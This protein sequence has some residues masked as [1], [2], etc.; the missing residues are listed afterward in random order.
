MSVLTNKEILDKKE[1]NNSETNNE[2]TDNKINEMNNND[3]KK[4]EKEK[5]FFYKKV[6]VKPF[7]QKKLNKIDNINI[8]NKKL[9][10]KEKNYIKQINR[11]SY[12]KINLTNNNI[13]SRLGFK[14]NLNI[15]DYSM[16]L[17][18]K[19]EKYFNN[20]FSSIGEINKLSEKNNTIDSSNNVIKNNIENNKN[21][22]INERNKNDLKLEMLG[23]DKD[24]VNINYINT[25]SN[26]VYGKINSPIY[27]NKIF[28][29]SNTYNDN[30]D[31]FNNINDN[32]T[33]DNSAKRRINKKLKKK[34]LLNDTNPNI[35]MNKTNEE[36]KPNFD[37]YNSITEINPGSKIE[38]IELNSFNNNRKENKMDIK[39][40]YL[41]NK[42][43]ILSS[44]EREKKKLLEQ[45]YQNYIKYISLIQKQQE[46]YKEY[47]Q[48]LKSELIKN[49]NSQIKLQLYKENYFSIVKNKKIKEIQIGN[50]WQR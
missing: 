11:N 43:R 35:D 13:N 46:Q 6:C 20:N 50:A 29:L 2:I 7:T 15:N 38:E 28:S 34:I 39:L 31:L 49:R 21:I 22:I 25:I 5:F 9:F 18:N 23:K 16:N 14:N 40:N 19:N 26:N 3:A 36:M 44:I 4:S 41:E 45:N 33:L 47:D 30:L 12:N 27:L 1:I 17:I 48:Y 42:K 32:D 24:K 10:T 37:Y 8:P